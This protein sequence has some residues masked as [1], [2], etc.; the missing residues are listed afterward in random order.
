MSPERSWLP[1][2]PTEKVYEVVI[3]ICRKANGGHSCSQEEQHT[4]NI[5]YNTT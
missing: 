3:G 1:S 2:N 4:E 5:W